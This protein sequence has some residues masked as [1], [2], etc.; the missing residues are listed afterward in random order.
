MTSL[1]II[2]PVYNKERY[3]DECICSILSQTFRD[4]ELLLI[5]DG[6]TDNSYSKCLEYGQ[7]DSR[8]IVVDQT[9]AGVSAARNKG[10]DMASGAY[11]GFVD[12]DDTISPDMYETLMKNA[13][14]NAADVSVCGM[15]V[16]FPYKTLIQARSSAQI[17]YQHEEALFAFLKG[18]FNY[19]ANNKIVKSEVLKRFRFEGRMYEDILLMSKI[20]LAA[21]RTVFQDVVGYHYMVRDNSASMSN[22]GPQYFETTKV[23]SEMVKLV[24]REKDEIVSAAKAFDVMAH[25]SLLNLLLMAGKERYL[26]QYHQVQAHLK[27]YRQFI[28]NNRH[29]ARK[30]KYAFLL[31][32]ASPG[33]YA[34]MMYF[35]CLVT[36]S[37]V[38]S[39]TKKD[40]KSN[41]ATDK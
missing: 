8:V 40:S 27:K 34:S 39:R 31:Y 20:F 21:G 29:V 19:S 22:F 30:H 12:G 17:T 4:F 7:K 3:I 10:L 5:N 33:V 16:T 41:P 2:V 38:I 25:I 15:E 26:V 32:T 28:K 1:S 23:S 11:I 35:Y 14:E 24:S 18:E 36:K 6:S 37:E 9:N 13:L